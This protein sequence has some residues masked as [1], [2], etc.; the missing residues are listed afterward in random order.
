MYGIILSNKT[1]SLCFP[2]FLKERSS[3]RETCDSS[4]Q[5]QNEEAVYPQSAIMTFVEHISAATYF[6]GP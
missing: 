3:K 4:N 5:I 1:Y 6:L 2:L